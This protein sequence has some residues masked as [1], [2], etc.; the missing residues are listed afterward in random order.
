MG[1]ENERT[2][3]LLPTCRASLGDLGSFIQFHL[4]KADSQREHLFG[5]APRKV[6][7]KILGGNSVQ[8]FAH[9]LDC[10]AA[11]I[12]SCVAFSLTVYTELRDPILTC[13]RVPINNYVLHISLFRGVL[14]AKRS[15]RH[16]T[17]HYS[18]TSSILKAHSQRRGGYQST[19]MQR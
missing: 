4:T 6:N 15:S 2:K 9:T 5:I 11:S 19:I 3:S 8:D 1:T 13:E 17:G 7:Q 12:I 14:S 16:T 10:A 18:T